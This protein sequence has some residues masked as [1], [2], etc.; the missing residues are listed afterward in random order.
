MNQKRP[1]DETGVTALARIWQAF[2][3][4]PKSFRER[5]RAHQAS[6]S[7]ADLLALRIQES[8]ADT[9]ELTRQFLGLAVPMWI[10]KMRWWPGR[11]RERRAHELGEELAASQGLVADDNPEGRVPRS[12]RGE[13]APQFNLLAQGLGLLALCPGGVVFAGQHW[14]AEPGTADPRGEELSP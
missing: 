6:L 3:P 5:Q 11:Y 8:Y 13:V 1:L 2:G 9:G 12:E 10:E 14:Q 7:D 4:H